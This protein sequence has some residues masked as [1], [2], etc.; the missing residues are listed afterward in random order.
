MSECVF[1]KIISKVLLGAIT[2]LYLYSSPVFAM[3]EEESRHV[4]RSIA[5][6]EGEEIRT[7]DAP[8]QGM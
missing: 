6:H 5:P 3:E 4:P 8:L 7:K 2:T 1:M